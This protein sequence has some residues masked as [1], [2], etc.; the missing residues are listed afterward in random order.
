LSDE[1]KNTFTPDE[2]IIIHTYHPEEE[3]W[4]YVTKLMSTNY[5]IDLI[6]ERIDTNFY[7]LNIAKLMKIKEKYN[8]SKNSIEVYEPLSND[9]NIK[10]NAREIGYTI[11]QAIELYKASQTVSLYAKPVLLYYSY[12]RLAR[13]LF[14]ATY[15]KNTTHKEA[16]GLRMDSN[17]VRCLKAGAFARFQDSFDSNPSIYLED[18]IFWMA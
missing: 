14:L 2:P 11:R 6:N 15:K 3:I 5:I 9:K 16:H 12:T 18:H 7:G 4:H 8:D 17:D 1:A 13:A 10:N